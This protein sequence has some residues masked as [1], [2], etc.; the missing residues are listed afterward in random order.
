MKG[1]PEKKEIKIPALGLFEMVEGAGERMKLIGKG[2]VGDGEG[3]EVAVVK[4]LEI[5]LDASEVF[6][7]IQGVKEGR[8]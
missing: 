2:S 3:E 8:L 4:G 5:Y 1:D 6:G 7:R